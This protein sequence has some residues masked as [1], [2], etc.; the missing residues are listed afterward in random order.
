MTRI[1]AALQL[2]YKP[3]T[4]HVRRG[5][6]RGRSSS[7]LC[8][9]CGDGTANSPEAAALRLSLKAYAAFLRREAMQVRWENHQR[10]TP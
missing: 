1:I 7:R 6:L 4:H 10:A 3:R 9:R 5:P 8:D 2:A